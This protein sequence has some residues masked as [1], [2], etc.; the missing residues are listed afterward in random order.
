MA[1][2]GSKTTVG[3]IAHIVARSP[4]GPR[5]NNPLPI[6]E[7]DEYSNLILLCPT[8]HKI[9][10]ENEADWPIEVLQQL[11][12]DH[13]KWVANQLESG[14]ISVRDLEG[15][16]FLT[17]HIENFIK[18]AGSAT[19]VYTA[20]TPLAINNEA[21]DPKSECIVH[22]INETSLPTA[23]ALNPTVNKTHTRPSEF[24][25]LN[26]DFR[27]LANGKGHHIEVFRSGHAEMKICIEG[28]SLEFTSEQRAKPGASRVKKLVYYDDLAVCLESEI[29]F[30]LRVWKN[31]LPFYNMIF[32]AVI[33]ATEG[34][35]LAYPRNKSYSVGSNFLN[36]S[37][38]FDRTLLN[39]EVFHAALQRFVECYGWILPTLRRENGCLSLPQLFGRNS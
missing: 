18:W 2:D 10:D 25:L 14:F 23:H 4:A 38:V 32:S 28:A 12:E 11:K 21:I 30:L 5:G 6:A 13:E 36:F 31:C 24:G 35:N 27:D 33:T 9:V 20:L 37:R 26:E 39:D 7:R 34:S 15:L 29:N 8:H 17:N 16:E 19:W 3:E 22:S 1:P